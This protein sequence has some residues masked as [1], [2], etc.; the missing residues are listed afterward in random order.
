MV[1]INGTLEYFK[2]GLK[3]LGVGILTVIPFAIIMYI[4]RFLI[5]NL[6]VQYAIGIIS[7]PLYLLL[8]GY[9]AYKLWGWN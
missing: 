1:K 7:I 4:V 9:I 3:G 5:E 2:I 8:W 6:A